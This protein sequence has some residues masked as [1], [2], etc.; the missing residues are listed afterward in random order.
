MKKV[1]LAALMLVSVQM[2]GQLKFTINGNVAG[3]KDTV[4]KIYY[5]YRLNGDWK[6]DSVV[7]TDKKYTIS[8][9]LE[10]P[11][12]AYIRASYK[13]AVPQKINQKRD[14]LSIYL[15]GTTMTAAHTDSFSN[16]TVKGSKSND[17]Y[18]S[19]NEKMKPFNAEIEQLNNQYRT[20]AANK[21]E[22]GI[23]KL[24]EV[25]EDIDRRQKA[26]YK[27]EFLANPN[28]PIALYIIER[29]AG[30]DINA[31]DV[32]PLFAK[33]PASAKDSKRGKE[34]SEKLNIARLTGIGKP[35][36]EF[37]QND[38]LGNPVSLAS[39]RGKYLLIDFW[40]SWC[41]PC[42][43]ENPNVVKAF[44]KYKEKGFYILGV[45]LDQP[46]AKDRWL[47]AIHDDQL[48]WTH[49]SDLQ[50]W[51]N[52]VAVQYGVQAI[53]QNFLIDPAGKIIAKNLRG[54]ALD[55]KLEELLK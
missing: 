33:L 37:T 4:D 5:N 31:D 39:L 3:I 40:A 46:N 44:N 30:Y 8:G 48:T 6:Q 38:T 22:A 23:A 21:D 11:S 20:L 29:F 13:R 34:L 9:I 10:E 1:L 54:E 41:G 52:A 49:V 17:A 7:V 28:S 27:S 53:P 24:E 32:D 50:Y 35:A 26:I 15:E 51:K 55:K 16:V 12:I 19:L 36:P 43:K 14:V 18:V 45:S 25:Y 2:Y 42:R 47:K